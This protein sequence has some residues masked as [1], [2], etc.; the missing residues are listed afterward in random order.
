[1]PICSV[2]LS[3]TA[4]TLLTMTG[5]KASFA[6]SERDDGKI[7]VSAR[8]LGDVNVQ[9]IMEK[10]N[11]GGHLTNAAT[12]IEDKTIDDVYNWLK[13]LLQTYYP[14]FVSQRWSSA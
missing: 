1:L 2:L 4:D 3:Q 8:S 14:Q 10:M 9:V 12:Q 6:I 5:I 11:G 13:E 7:G